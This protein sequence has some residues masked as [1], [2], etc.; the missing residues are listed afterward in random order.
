MSEFAG[1]LQW[2]LKK[3]RCV[4]VKKVKVKV[5]VKLKVVVRMGGQ[6]WGIRNW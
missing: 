1:S 3:S 6:V 4:K 5:K 2:K